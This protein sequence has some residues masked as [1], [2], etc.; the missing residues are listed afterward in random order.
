MPYDKVLL[1]TH[2]FISSAT[3]WK[4]EEI[5]SKVKTILALANQPCLSIEDVGL[6]VLIS[7]LERCYEFPVGNTF[8]M[9][10]FLSSIKQ[11]TPT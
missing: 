2:I 8:Q 3:V 7:H 6:C 9:L 1:D 4:A 5:T 10:P 11:F